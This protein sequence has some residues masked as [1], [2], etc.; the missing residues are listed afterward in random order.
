M[1]STEGTRESGAPRGPDAGATSGRPQHE[2]T[3]RNGQSHVLAA[4]HAATEPLD[5]HGIAAAVG[6]HV[7]TIRFHLQRL[8]HAGL[9]ERTPEPTNRPGRPRYRY[10]ARA[11]PA[12]ADSPET[13]DPARYRL[14]AELLSGLLATEVA[15]PSEAALRAGRALGRQLV[16]PPSAAGR[17]PDPSTA[18]DLL[19]TTLDGV[20]F[21]S[22]VSGDGSGNHELVITRCPYREMAVEHGDIVCSIHL[23]VLQGSLAAMRAPLVVEEFHP[24]VAPDRCLARLGSSPAGTDP[25]SGPVVETSGPTA[26]GPTASG[27]T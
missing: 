22:R 11:H 23:G 1:T 5:V 24:L 8:V 27:P 20:G 12:S 4:L 19:V 2:V 21:S 25:G 13:D 10:R 9:V 17:P 18:A 6:R 15:R 3:S 16:D 26:S 7:N 14:L